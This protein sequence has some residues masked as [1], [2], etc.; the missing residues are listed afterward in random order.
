MTEQYVTIKIRRG[1][2]VRPAGIIAKAAERFVSKITLIREAENEY[3]NAKSALGIVSLGARYN[4]SLLVRAEGPDEAQ[5]VQTIVDLFEQ[6][7]EE[8]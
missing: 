4:T 8:D 6:R 3:I 1:L 7:F 5:A 2:H